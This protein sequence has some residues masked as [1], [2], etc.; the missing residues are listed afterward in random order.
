MKYNAPSIPFSA[1]V[2]PTAAAA[3]L[4][5]A[6]CQ[7]RPMLRERA[8]IPMPLNHPPAAVEALEVE[9]APVTGSVSAPLMTPVVEVEAVTVG[10]ELPPL[11]MT[12]DA[13]IVYTVEKG[14]SLWKIARKYGVD[15]K[16]L[17]SCNNMSLDAK[18]H[19]GDTL[20][21]PPGGKLI[22]ADKLPPLPKRKK[23]PASK[24]TAAPVKRA[25]RPSD[26]EYIVKKGDSLWKIAMRHNMKTSTL[27]DANN[28]PLNKVLQPGDKII[29]PDGKNKAAVKTAAPEPAVDAAPAPA[30]EEMEVEVVSGDRMAPEEGNETDDILSELADDVG[31]S[32][33][34]SA[35][36]E[37]AAE[38]LDEPAAAVR[39]HEVLPGETIDAVAK[40]YGTSAEVIRNLNPGLPADGKLEVGERIKIP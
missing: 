20:N 32:D 27:A 3:C 16:E 8:N 15:Y 35:T 30:V 11:E 26:G 10:E 5:A 17:A 38:L 23:S 18:I 7:S 28:L 2:V 4:L 6:G 31:V 19:P 36:D 21:I 33:Y 9:M 37:A 25:P 1:L 12:A 13:P 34:D 39:D 24:S 22:P 14:D 40:Q 29:I